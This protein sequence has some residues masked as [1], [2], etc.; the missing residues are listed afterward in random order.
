MPH[1]ERVLPTDLWERFSAQF[2]RATGLRLSLL[3]A[4]GLAIAS[5]PDPAAVCPGSHHSAGGPCGATY[6]KAAQQV[7]ASG[8]ATLFRCPHGFLVFAAPVDRDARPG[9]E[10]AV[11]VGGPALGEVPTEA[12]ADALARRVE[13]SPQEVLSFLQ[14]LP[15]VAPRSLLEKGHLAQL[16]L[17]T[18]ISGSRLREEYSRR[19]SQVMTLFEVSSDLAQA[20]S[21]HEL[22]ALALNILGVLF[23]VECAAILLRDAGGGVYR[24]QTAMG[25]VEKAL[26]PWTVP[27]DSAPLA[28]RPA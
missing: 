22:H 17:R 12:T 3:D 2:S 24:V 7:L 11:L 21:E 23:D 8:E 14:G 25:T 10:R 13:G 15:V 26:Q 5:T 28:E 20:A 9:S 6:R 1:L 4:E 16:C 19:Q 27:L 18:V